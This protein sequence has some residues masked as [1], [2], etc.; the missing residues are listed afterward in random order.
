MFLYYSLSNCETLIRLFWRIC[1]TER[2][3]TLLIGPDFAVPLSQL[4]PIKPDTQTQESIE[5]WHYWVARN[6]VF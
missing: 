6:Y 2:P 5:D 4:Y 1:D 3:S